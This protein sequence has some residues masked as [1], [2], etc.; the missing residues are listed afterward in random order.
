MDPAAFVFFFKEVAGQNSALVGS[1]S[2]GGHGDYDNMLPVRKAAVAVQKGLGT[3]LRGFGN[4][5]RNF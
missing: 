5:R 3:R 4:L 1:G 2:F